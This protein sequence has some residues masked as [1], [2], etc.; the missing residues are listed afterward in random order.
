MTLLSDFDPMAEL[1]S[2]FPCKEGTG[3]ALDCKRSL[4][5][6]KVVMY[7]RRDRDSYEWA[8]VG[9]RDFV[10]EEPSYDRWSFRFDAPQI[11][12]PD[13][14][15]LF[16]F[17]FVITT[18]DGEHT[19]SQN[20]W[21]EGI[22]I[23]DDPAALSRWQLSFYRPDYK[24]PAW[25]RGAVMYQVFPDRFNRG[26]GAPKREDAVI[27]DDW[28]NGLPEYA[29]EKNGHI[30][31]NT[32][33]GGT[34]YGVIDKLD[35]LCSLGVNVIYLNPI[36][37]AYSN[38][39]YDTGDYSKVDMMFGGDEAFD[40]LI[41]ECK[42]RNM[43][44]ILDGVFNHT[45]ADSLYFNKNKRYGE[46][47]AYNDESSPYNWYRFI[48]WN[49]KYDSWWGVRSLP[50]VD[51]QNENWREYI[52]GEKGIVRRWIGRGADGWR[53]DVA[54]ELSEPFLRSLRKSAKKE[55]PDALV[56]GEVWEDASNKIS[57]SA[58]RH[59]FMGEELDCVMNYPLRNAIISYAR[60]GDADFLFATEKILYSHYP[61][62]VSDS[63][64]NILG[65][66]DTERILT[67]LGGSPDGCATNEEMAHSRLSGQ[68]RE[69][70]KKRLMLASALLYTLP[71]VPCVY[72]G[73]EAGMEGYGDPFC[74]RPYPWG[75]EDHEIL[76]HYRKLGEIRRAEK[77]FAEGYYRCVTHNGAIFA[78]ERFSGDE[79]IL[80]VAN[81]SGEA[82]VYELD[83]RYR[84]LV[85]GHFVPSE[86]KLGAFEVQIL[87]KI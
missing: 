51:S 24:T 3:A 26:R 63:L 49:D 16:Y 86:L 41:A 37:E 52:L 17:H 84:S 43:K 2:C 21:G 36:F 38:H 83:C 40:S 53:L 22:V 39:K 76:S 62:F 54:D 42:K 73:D 29:H 34:L 44:V 78:F 32:F 50:A 87:K 77:L 31:N 67:V 58:R 10:K 12:A 20:E 68:A 65:T 23:D 28:Y 75:R 45:G 13:S 46:G 80:V 19:V 8:L 15:G 48:S 18:P 82:A 79:S 30:D 6:S 60:D 35:Y 61:K 57:Y 25:I 55:N 85:S 33:F 11:C 74:R 5:V 1:F 9:E 72:Y 81:A 71:G 4:A 14:F 7:L 64:M 47:G 66:H 59:Y 27:I 56:L 69:D 70:A